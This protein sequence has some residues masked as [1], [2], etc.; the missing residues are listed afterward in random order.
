MP[1]T[2]DVQGQSF[3]PVT[4]RQ[5]MAEVWLPEMLGFREQRLLPNTM[6]KMLTGNVKKGDKFHIPRIGELDVADKVTDSAIPLQND[7]NDDYSITVDT[8]RV[9]AIGIDNIVEAIS[10]YAIRSEYVRGMG[11]SMAKDISGGILGLR[12]AVYN[13]AAQ[14]IFVSSTGTLAGNGLPIDLASL[15]AAREILLEADVPMEDIVVLFSTSQETSLLSILQA[16]S[17]DY[18]SGR[19]TESGVLGELYGAQFFRSTLVGANSATGWKRRLADGTKQLLPSPGFA[20][21]RYLPKQD[22]Y[23][24]LPATFGGNS[25]PVHTALMCSREWA[26]CIMQ[27]NVTPETNYIPEKMLHMVAARH[28]YGMKLF[29][30]DHAVLIH[31]AG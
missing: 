21:S 30:K 9:V 7:E 13:I 11:Y 15:L 18:V 12:A 14:N 10:S 22:T 23:T 28:T 2:N 20:G 29:R 24:T 8:D 25:A 4:A 27:S 19:P 26:A 1:L 17:S 31:S 6:C 3:N 5:F 16:T